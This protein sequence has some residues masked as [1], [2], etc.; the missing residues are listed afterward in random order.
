MAGI[1]HLIPSPISSGPFPLPEY[2]KEIFRSIPYIISERERTT[3]RF[4]SSFLTPAELSQK[5]FARFDE[6]STEGDLEP[7]LYPVVQ[8]L[9]AVSYT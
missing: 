5:R 1:L 8:G 9:D 6:H 7:L 2:I 4:L 3:L